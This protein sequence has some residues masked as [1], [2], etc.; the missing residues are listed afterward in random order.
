M[1]MVQ[2][3]QSLTLEENMYLLGVELNFA[4]SRSMYDHG[5]AIKNA[6][7]KRR[8]ARQVNT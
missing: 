5:L 1:V 8:A 2:R 6:T 3:F 7:T 4:K